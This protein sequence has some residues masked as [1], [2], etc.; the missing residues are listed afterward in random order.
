MNVIE[1]NSKKANEMI[2]NNKFNLIID[3]REEGLYLE[4]HIPGAIN[5]P[6]YE[7]NDHI[8]YLRSI[9]S[10]NILLYCTSG[11]QSLSVGKVLLISGFKNVYSLYNGIENY[12]YKIVK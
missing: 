11:I 1:I 4:G 5:I 2:K 9:S 8:D 3:L 7:I 6:T 12:N 10:K